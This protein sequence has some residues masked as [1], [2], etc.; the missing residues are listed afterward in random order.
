MWYD[1]LNIIGSTTCIDCSEGTYQRN[2]GQSKC[3]SCPSGQY[4]NQPS[5]STCNKCVAGQY[6]SLPGI[7]VIIHI[8]HVICMQLS[9][10]D[11][12]VI[13]T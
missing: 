11:L 6:T 8:H 10:T 2:P 1:G 3:D 7:T 9:L 5:Q 12:L 4:S 13:V